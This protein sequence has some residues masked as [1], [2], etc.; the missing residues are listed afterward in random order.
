MIEHLWLLLFI[1]IKKIEETKKITTRDRFSL[2]AIGIGTVELFVNI[3]NA[4]A[5]RCRFFEPVL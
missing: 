3:S 1:D 5:Q 4:G 2:E